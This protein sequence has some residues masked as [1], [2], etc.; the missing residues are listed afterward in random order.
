MNLGI[1]SVSF[2]DVVVVEIMSVLL[3]GHQKW[4]GFENDYSNSIYTKYYFH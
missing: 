4:I 3:Q 2:L 1:D